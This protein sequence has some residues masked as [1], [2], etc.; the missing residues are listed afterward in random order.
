M[1]KIRESVQKLYSSAWK[2][3]R[4][5][6]KFDGHIGASAASS[7]SFWCFPVMKKTKHFR[8]ILGSVANVCEQSLETSRTFFK[9]RS[10]VSRRVPQTR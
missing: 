4:E 7:H 3:A 6:A 1:T 10:R 9:H 2:V 8:G 5:D